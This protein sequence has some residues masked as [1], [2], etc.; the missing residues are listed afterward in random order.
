MQIYNKFLIS[1][2]NRNFTGYM[3]SFLD[4]VAANLYAHYG[5]Q[6][7]SCSL[8][9]PNRRSRLFFAQI[10]SKLIDKPLW[11]PRYNT[12]E[13]IIV[14]FS[15]QQVSD[16]FALLLELY[17]VYSQNLQRQE[18]F[19]RFYFWGEVML[20]DFD[21]IDKYRIK[22]EALFSNLKAQKEL[23]DDFSFLNEDQIA[24]IRQFWNSF[25]PDSSTLQK[26]F[27]KIWEKLWPIYCQFREQLKS[28]GMA[29]E[30]MLYRKV[31][32]IDLPDKLDCECFVFIGFNALNECEKALFNKLKHVGKVEFYWDYDNYYLN[33]EQQEAGLFLRRNVA[34]FPS[35]LNSEQFSNFT[36]E[37]IIKVVAAPSDAVQAK[38]VPQ[39]I[40][41]MEAPADNRTAVVLADEQLLIPTLHA[42]PAIASDINV[43][44]GYP[45]RQTPVYA[46]INLLLQVHHKAKAGSSGL[47]FYHRDVL[48]ILYHPYIKAAAGKAAE[49]LASEIVQKNKVYV[50]AHDFAGHS[51]LSAIFTPA[52]TYG[53]LHQCL[54]CLLEQIAL[55]P[56]ADE[57]K[58]MIHAYVLHCSRQLN[59]LKK[60]LDESC[61]CLSLPVYTN[62]L[63]KLLANESIPFTGEPLSGLQVLGILETRNL[64]FEHLIM[65]SAN[66]GIIPRSYNAP[67][68]I[69]YNLRRGFGL[70]TIEQHEAVYAYYFY[71]LLQRAKKITLVYNTKTDESHS[72]EMSRYIMQLKTESE[73]QVQ[74]SSVSFHIGL[75]PA[76]PIVVPKDERVLEV[77]RKYLVE[78][79]EKVRGTGYEVRGENS[80]F[81]IQNL[82]FNFL[83]PSA[84]NAYLACSLQ[85]YF[86]YIE[87]L[88]APD[89]MTE[90]VDGILLGNLLHRTME[91]LYKLPKSPEGGVD[92]AVITTEW[93]R[94]LLN[95][96]E[97]IKDSLDKALAHEYYHRDT[98][99][100]EADE[101]GKLVLLRE[102][103]SKYIYQIIRYDI[104]QTPF[105]LEGTELRF[106]HNFPFKCGDEIKHIRLGGIVDRLDRQGNRLL[107]VD[108]KTGRAKGEFKGV[109][110]LFG[111][112]AQQHNPAVLQIMLY[113]MLL[114]QQQPKLEIT[115][116]LYFMRKL[117][118]DS[119]FMITDKS[120]KQSIT[121][122]TPYMESYT[123]ALSGILSELFNPQQAFEQ[124]SDADSCAMCDYRKICNH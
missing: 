89:E 74:E 3:T 108:Y 7:S 57:N 24:H 103:V 42:L 120:N 23:E 38:L 67:S 104:E 46:L 13:E 60:A 12:I 101:D 66:E 11:Q 91:S 94:T 83:T 8:I 41:E 68:F 33:D 112:D 28:K 37:K 87:R 107:V 10:L 95:N 81:K 71:R 32:E 45:L 34:D 6:L 93:L 14:Q 50:T 118:K 72:G 30:G 21:L 53:E 62:M 51:F 124:T 78:E 119:N 106:H 123:A 92:N 80:K 25:D 4:I 5:N 15:G 47:R 44:M 2:K 17:E 82:K 59:K 69:P 43:T 36:T 22:A 29:Y 109:E 49:I 102:V 79:G 65:L 40:K 90:D 98:L 27:L 64:D 116:K 54:L 99:P 97:L 110:A 75:H 26:E 9:F 31:A 121:D 52:L 56:L 113:S 1:Q 20:H 18:P 19:D 117:Y 111:A 122:I 70:P 35:P 55:V 115:P 86:R 39:L 63:Y 85:F 88:K 61:V 84:I 96:H 58:Q 16:S 77:L 100:A 73:Q 76:N 105:T 48:A 114:K